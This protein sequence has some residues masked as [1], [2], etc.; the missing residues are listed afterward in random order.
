MPPHIASET[1]H[2]SFS[3]LF[4]LPAL[5]RTLNMFD[6]SPLYLTPI[7]FPTSSTLDITLTTE[8]FYFTECFLIAFNT[9]FISLQVIL[10]TLVM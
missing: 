8:D 7:A 4:F 9:A 3:P 2:F 5:E 6:L 10:A 1:V